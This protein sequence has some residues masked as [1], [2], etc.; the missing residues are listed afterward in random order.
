VQFNA[1]NYEQAK[2][3]VFILV[4]YLYWM[5]MLLLFVGCFCNE[6]LV[7][8]QSARDLIHTDFV[9]Y[10]KRTSFQ[11]N[12]F[13]ETIA[14]TFQTSLDSNTESNYREAC[15]AISQ[16]LL[17][18]NQIE[19]GFS[20][21]FSSYESLEINSKRAF[22]EAVYATYPVEYKLQIQQL[23]TKETH[24]KLFS[25]QALYLY[26]VDASLANIQYLLE[27][28]S[29]R[30]LNDSSL[31]ILKTLANYLQ[32]HTAQ[33]KQATPSIV[34]LFKYQKNTAQ[35]TIYSFQRWNR[36]YPGIA[37]IQNADGHFLRDSNGS[38]I[39]AEQLARAGSNLPYFITNGNTPQG[40]YSIQG[41]EVS[42]NLFIGPTPNL[43]LLM[44]FEADSIFWHTPY[45]ASK[46]SMNNYKNLWPL[47]WRNYAPITETF[48]AGKIG[49]TEILAHGTTID[50]DYFK[51]MPFFPLTPTLGCLCAKENWNIFTGKLLESDQFSLASGFLSTPKNTGY[52]MVINLDNQ[53]KAVSKQ[54]IEALIVQ[55]EKSVK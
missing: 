18:S 51:G 47:E 2:L 9:L 12:L 25:M 24:P 54:E 6:I 30:F 5:K 27:T 43:Q 46:D 4:P 38:I 40:I 14:K 50:P 32:N 53:L 26:R 42:H 21:L 34:A 52:L 29:S 13:N 15:W 49:R 20:R 28:I 41:T 16:F 3:Q 33:I 22:L 55:F 19:Q 44:P 23:I 39:F 31:P 45:D 17:R 37:V 10:E 48:D 8:A 36:D 1:F 35:K 11:N 7:Q